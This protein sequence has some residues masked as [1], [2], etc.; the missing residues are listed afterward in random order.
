MSAKFGGEKLDESELQ[1]ILTTVK[2][3]TSNFDFKPQLERLQSQRPQP[4]Q[5]QPQR[6]QPRQT[7]S[8]QSQL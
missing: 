7:Q 6:P 3:K 2:K 4:Q 8:Q 1:L 5:P